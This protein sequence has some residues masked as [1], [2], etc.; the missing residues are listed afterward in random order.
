MK[1]T[2]EQINAVLSR[3]PDL[4][5]TSN[6]SLQEIEDF[7]NK[8]SII[9]MFNDIAAYN[10]MLQEKIV[11][12]N[13]DLTKVVPFTRE[14]LY[15]MCAFSGSG[16]STASANISYPLWKQKKK[17]LIIS[18]EEA[19]QDVLFRIAAIE[20]GVNFNDYKK[21]RMDNETKAKVMALFPDIGKYVKVIDVNFRNGFTTKIEC[22]MQALDT[23]AKEDYSCVMIDYLQL[24]T[25]SSIPGDKRP[26]FE[27][28]NDF[29]KYIGM[30]IK[31]A[32][33]P[34]VLFAQLHSAGKRSKDID[35]RIKDI[36]AIME[37]ATVVIEIV[38]NFKDRSTEFLIIKD[39]FGM[40]GTKLSCAF[41]NGRFV[42]M[43][44]EHKQAVL[45]ERLEDIKNGVASQDDD[46]DEDEDA[47]YQ[48]AMKKI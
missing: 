28:L 45:A 30:Y 6:I 26:R 36:P 15:L 29:K 7:G 25:G 13:D 12:I 46:D 24:I 32:S 27:I 23:V 1:L 9:E 40:Q 11:F 3:T 19:K 4:Q 2:E 39:R 35:S 43:T 37:P 47:D 42:T 18:N 20:L 31:R 22:V 38:P 17:T 34:V 16:K 44:E 10:K 5:N 48:D 21:G 33:C 8:E 41:S 14:N